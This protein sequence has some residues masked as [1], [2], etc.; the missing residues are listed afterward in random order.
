[1]NDRF[2]DKCNEHMRKNDMK[3][4]D[5]LRSLGLS[6][7]AYADYC[8]GALPRVDKALRIARVIKCDVTELWS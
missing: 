1:M 5:F 3:V 2:R 6:K 8:N 4:V 7:N